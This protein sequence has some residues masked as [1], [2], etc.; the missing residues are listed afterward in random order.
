MVL[1]IGGY[2]ILSVD[3]GFADGSWPEIFRFL[4]LLVPLS[5]LGGSIYYY[6]I[7]NEDSGER[8]IFSRS[9]MAAR[10]QY[11]YMFIFYWNW[12]CVVLYLYIGSSLSMVLFVLCLMLQLAHFIVYNFFFEEVLVMYSS[13]RYEY[14]KTCFQTHHR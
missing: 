2:Y 1:I 9:E 13:Q 14:G 7:L 4:I 11:V 6:S 5:Y 12:Y 3:S 10:W 8:A